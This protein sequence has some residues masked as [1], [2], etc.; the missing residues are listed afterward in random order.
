VITARPDAGGSRLHD[1]EAGV[2][3]RGTKADLA[4]GELLVPGRESN[5]EAGR[6]MNHVYFT[7]TLSAYRWRAAS[8][9]V[10]SSLPILAHETPASRA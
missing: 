10:P 5:F 1:Y 2:H 8:P 7:A 3:L 4:V 6:V 9:V